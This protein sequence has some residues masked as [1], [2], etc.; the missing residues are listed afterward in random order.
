MAGR[1][2]PLGMCVS[3]RS[4]C[5]S[6]DW[7]GV[8]IRTRSD[9]REVKMGERR[10]GGTGGQ[11]R[12]VRFVVEH[13]EEAGRGTDPFGSRNQKSPGYPGVHGGPLLLVEYQNIGHQRPGGFSLAGGYLPATRVLQTA[14]ST[15]PTA[16]PLRLIVAS[17]YTTLCT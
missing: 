15:C 17:C 7:L 1:K 4:C 16:K 9:R 10:N 8:R 6:T 3:P 13:S 5:L 2:W 11:G 12:Q 14:P